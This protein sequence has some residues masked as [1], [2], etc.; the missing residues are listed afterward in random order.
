MKKNTWVQMRVSTDQKDEWLK[1]SEKEG[2]SLSMWITKKLG[3]ADAKRK[4][5]E[6]TQKQSKKICSKA[7]GKNESK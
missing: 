3:G 5:R 7:N 2:L 1:K 6:I 4:Q